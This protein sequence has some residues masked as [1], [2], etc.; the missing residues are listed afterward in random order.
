MGITRWDPFDDLVALRDAFGRMLGDTSWRTGLSGIGNWR[1]SVDMY[2]TNDDVV[3]RADLPGVDRDNLEVT[4]TDNSLTI[5]GESKR[6][7]EMESG[8][9]FRRERAYGQF[10]RTLP[11]SAGIKADEAKASFNHGVLEIVIPKTEESKVR[12]RRIEIN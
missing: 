8:S 12:T 10:M 7:H 3:V 4:V 5:K 9:V 11:I 2:E 6:E 1:P